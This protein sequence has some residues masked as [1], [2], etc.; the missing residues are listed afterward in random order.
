MLSATD[1]L[2]MTDAEFDRALASPAVAWALA[3]FF[4][5]FAAAE[6]RRERQLPRRRWDERVRL[7]R[8]AKEARDREASALSAI[9]RTPAAMAALEA[10]MMA[11]A[12][13]VDAL[14]GLTCWDDLS[15]T[16]LRVIQFAP[17][18]GRQMARCRFVR[19]AVSVLVG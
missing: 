8:M 1:P 6:Y 11:A 9:P 12:A 13:D 15:E 3:N 7:M 14:A 17:A 19:R 18:T 2:Q 5:E 4:G 16:A 10:A